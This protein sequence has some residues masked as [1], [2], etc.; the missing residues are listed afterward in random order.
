MPKA[1][2]PKKNKGGRPRKTAILATGKE[3]AERFAAGM[4]HVLKGGPHPKDK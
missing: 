3:S 4:A 2:K 1:P